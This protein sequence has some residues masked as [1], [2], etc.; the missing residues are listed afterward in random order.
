M[1]VNIKNIIYT[2]DASEKANYVLAVIQIIAAVSGYLSSNYFNKADNACLHNLSF[3]I[4]LIL[5]IIVILYFFLMI[6]ISSKYKAIK[7]RLRRNTGILYD[8]TTNITNVS[9]RQQTLSIILEG[10]DNRTKL[11]ETGKI[12]GHSFYKDFENKLIGSSDKIYKLTEKLEKW[13]NYDSSSGMGKFEISYDKGG[14]VDKINIINPFTGDCDGNQNDYNLCQFL[15]GYIE[16]FLSGLYGSQ[17]E[18][19]CKHRV[20]P[21]KQCE[22]TV[23]IKPSLGMT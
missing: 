13:K 8:K 6:L 10:L 1:N 14:F 23:N 16:G 20:R 22:Y 21:E 4:F 15:H 12:V 3:W 2:I 9:L 19:K 18:V 11:Y 5:Q 7:L 17:V